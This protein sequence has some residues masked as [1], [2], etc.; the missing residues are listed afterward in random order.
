MALLTDELRARIGETATYT[1]PEE[2]GRSAFR[3]FGLAVGDYNPLYVDRRAASRAGLR[4]VMAPPTLICE[5]NQYM[6]GP[7]DAD[8][9]IGHGWGIEI[10]DTRL[11]RG[12]NEYEFFQP[13]HPDDVVTATWT[14]E[15][16]AERQTSKGADML[17]VTSKA[18][19]TNQRGETI[20]TNRETLIWT[21]L[22]AQSPSKPE[23]AS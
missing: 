9:Y 16:M 23:E 15:D 8:G 20:A 19:Y 2:V 14:I 17:V 5:T 10:P 6:I 21:A 13:M 3:Y 7:R 1:A 22:P 4:D 18:T 11:V 12:G